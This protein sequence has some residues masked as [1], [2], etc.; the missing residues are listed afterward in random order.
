MTKSTQDIAKLRAEIE[1][2]REEIDWL[3]EAPVTKD[4]LK[5]RAREYYQ[6]LADRFDAPRRLGQ[7]A[8]PAAG[9]VEVDAMFRISAKVFIHGQLDVT[10]ADSN[11]AGP[12]LAWVMGET[13][14]QRMHAEIDRLD[15]RPGPPMAERPARLAALKATLRA[16]EQQEEA[17]ILRTEETSVYIP[18]RTDADPAVILAYDPDCETTDYGMARSAKRRAAWEGDAA[19]PDMATEASAPALAAEPAS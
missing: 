12:M 5:S 6:V 1:R 18:R 4:E 19:E 17:L 15:Y 3:K 14:V 2:C 13:L 11:D 16:L 10:S 7:L 8:N 9:I